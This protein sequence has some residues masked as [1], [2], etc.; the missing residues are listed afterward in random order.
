M[1]FSQICCT[2]KIRR[3]LPGDKGRT[4]S[5]DSTG[6]LRQRWTHPPATLIR[7]SQE[8]RAVSL[9][10]AMRTRR[11]PQP[12]GG[13]KQPHL[14]KAAIPAGHSPVL[15]PVIGFC[16]GDRGVPEEGTLPALPRT[17]LGIGPEEPDED[18]GFGGEGGNKA[19]L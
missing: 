4:N 13:Q 16:P 6:R 12:Q 14:G 2:E 7:E 11:Q 3:L 19:K 5:V 8:V 1:C 15:C 18:L 9:G 10:T 17:E